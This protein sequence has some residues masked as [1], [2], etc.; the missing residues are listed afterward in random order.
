MPL[1]G[2]SRG[3]LV[4]SCHAAG[5]SGPFIGFKR[6]SGRRFAACVN[7]GSSGMLGL[8]GEYTM[9]ENQTQPGTR[10]Q[11][12]GPAARAIDDAQIVEL[13][14]RPGEARQKIL[15]EPSAKCSRLSSSG[16]PL[17]VGALFSRPSDAS[18]CVVD[19]SAIRTTRGWREEFG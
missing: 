1:G 19:D 18:V 16:P 10:H 13:V 8:G 9:E 6:A 14:G 17:A 15:D 4:N 3:L 2:Q 7:A 12:R 5:F 11:I